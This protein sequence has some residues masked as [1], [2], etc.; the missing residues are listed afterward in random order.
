MNKQSMRLNFVS[1]H[2]LASG[3]Q[4]RFIQQGAGLSGNACRQR[5]R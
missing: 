2:A 1:D 3:E 4:A 5:T